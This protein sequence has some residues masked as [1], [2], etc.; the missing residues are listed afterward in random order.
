MG[1]GIKQKKS[2]IRWS[3][4]GDRDKIQKSYDGDRDKIQ[5]QTMGT[6]IKIKNKFKTQMI[7]INS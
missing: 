1:T 6:G 2:I 3:N 7:F 5:N 4:N